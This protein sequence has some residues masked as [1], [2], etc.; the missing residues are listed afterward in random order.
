MILNPPQFQ[1]LVS[2][3]LLNGPTGSNS[4]VHDMQDRL[5]SSSVP[6]AAVTTSS[7]CALT[8]KHPP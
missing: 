4:R 2:P 6:T 7:A 3:V 8:H 1:G 5:Q